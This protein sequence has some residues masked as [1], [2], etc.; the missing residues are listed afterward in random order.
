[1]RFTPTKNKLE[2]LLESDEVAQCVQKVASFLIP[3]IAQKVYLLAEPAGLF[4]GVVKG[5]T[6]VTEG[7]EPSN[8]LS[9]FRII[10]RPDEMVV[11]GSRECPLTKSDWR[12]LG[13]G[14]A[15]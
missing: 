8:F 1:M 13:E 14:L 2:I 3:R 10:L 12:K 15:A 4:D 6:V 9:S 7:Q 5:V 11:V